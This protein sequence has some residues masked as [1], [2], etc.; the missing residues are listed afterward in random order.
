MAWIPFLSEENVLV[1]GTA[2]LLLGCA[3]QIGIAVW[4]WRQAG[5]GWGL[6]GLFLLVLVFP[7]YVYN[8]N[9]GMV[10]WPSGEP[11]RKF[12]TSLTAGSLIVASIFIVGFVIGVA[13]FQ[14]VTAPVLE[15]TRSTQ[16]R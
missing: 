3:I 9:R 1:A 4:I 10:K 14:E 13:L 8:Q 12:R 15:G 5:V 7:L 16:V 2:G 11:V 6:A